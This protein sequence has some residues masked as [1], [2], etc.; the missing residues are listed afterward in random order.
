VP[1]RALHPVTP[2]DT[3]A[4]VAELPK[5]E[6]RY[7]SCR[8]QLLAAVDDCAAYKLRAEKRFA[9]DSTVIAKLEDALRDRPPRRHWS[10]G[11]TA[12]YGGT[13]ASDS[14]GATR[15][16]HRPVAD[17]GPHLDAVLMTQSLRSAP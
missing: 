9:G 16:Y 6:A 17:G 1:T 12:G 7:Q 14:T 5:V 15:L 10:L 2:A 3:A 13:L 11:I 8:V 4:A